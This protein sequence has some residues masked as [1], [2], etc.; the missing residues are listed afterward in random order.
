MIVHDDQSVGVGGDGG[1]EDFARMNQE[2]IQRALGN[3]LDSNQA[4]AGI[5]QDGLKRL[6]FVEPVFLAQ[7][8]GNSLRGIKG[9]SF[10]TNFPGHALCERERAFQGDGLVAA[11][12]LHLAD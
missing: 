9:G 3:L 2:C 7:Q 1:A 10:G 5:E 6:N 12:A 11:D 8:F 4:P